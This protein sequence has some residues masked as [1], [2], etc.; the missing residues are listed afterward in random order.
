MGSDIVIYCHEWCSKINWYKICHF[1]VRCHRI[2]SNYLWS[3]VK[4]HVV[5]VMQR[6]VPPPLEDKPYDYCNKYVANVLWCDRGW[7]SSLYDLDNYW[8]F[9]D[10]LFFC[11]IE[12]WVKSESII[13]SSMFRLRHNL[14]FVNL[15]NATCQVSLE[16]PIFTLPALS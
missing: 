2:I 6:N 3:Q 11:L 5:S 9:D 8:S 4:W 15:L 14:N 10:F 7:H 1:C 16:H 12:R 13:S